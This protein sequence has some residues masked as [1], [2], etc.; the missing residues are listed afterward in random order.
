MKLSPA[1][2]VAFGLTL[3][4][5]TASGQ[6]PMPLVLEGE[7]IPG[8]GRIERVLNVRVVDGGRWL[9]TVDTDFPD[10]SRDGVLLLDGAPYARE[11]DALAAPAGTQ[12]TF[13]VDAGLTPSAQPIV[14]QVFTG[15]GSFADDSGLYLGPSLLLREGA[16]TPG[17]SWWPGTVWTFF[18][19]VDAPRDDLLL[20]RGYVDDPL[21]GGALDDFLALVRLD[22]A[23]SLLGVDSL[24]REGDVLP[25]ELYPV[26][27][28][29]LGHDRVGYAGDGS[30]IFSVGL[31]TGI[32]HYVGDSQVWR[33]DAQG[34]TRLV[35]EGD[36]APVVGRTWGPLFAPVVSLSD[37][38][39][40]VVRERLDSS[41]TSD[42]EIVVR[43][44]A[45]LVQEGDAHPA[46]GGHVV[47]TFGDGP[48]QL[49]GAGHL[50]WYARWSDPDPK[51]DSGLLLDG[52][53]IVREGATT[54]GDSLLSVLESGS[55]SRAISRDGRF[56]VFL[57][58]LRS[59]ERGAFRL[60]LADPVR[61]LCD[62]VAYATPCPCANEGAPGAGC[63]DGPGRPGARL[64]A[65]GAP[66]VS[67]DTLRLSVDGLRRAPPVVLLQGTAAA[68]GGSG[69][70][71]GDG[72]VC[73]GGTVRFLVV[74]F[75][76]QGTVA[77]GHG[78]GSSLA[79]LGA[80]SQ[81][82]ASVVYQ[83][84]YRSGGS[85]CTPQR[86]NLSNALQVTWG[87]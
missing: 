81:P 36:P 27:G 30:V 82:G 7:T 59:G 16:P 66:S 78:Q 69:V 35:R 57:G 28:L 55:D 47:R 2:L 64:R 32:P 22:A 48:V 54:V 58:Q 6:S 19:F 12:S 67:A 62:G 76:L 51:R 63:A 25:G 79:Q 10:S 29:S 40:W 15:T 31:D 9:A 18:S 1:R 53:L 17:P 61:S 74:S 84:L 21:I 39:D 8:V 49:D 43:N 13:F 26:G 65:G 3:C 56:V 11:G 86:I 44:G 83:A 20:L 45:K 50:L 42:D 71:L 68:N 46:L 70:A 38:G 41:D 87:P 34:F 80:I 75:A 5:A 52:R 72:V 4:M 24:V 73:V 37:A 85:F 14:S 60:D 77:F 23:G 33:R